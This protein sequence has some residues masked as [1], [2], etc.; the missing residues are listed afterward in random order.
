AMDDLYLDNI[1]ELVT[2]H[3]KIIS[4][5]SGFVCEKIYTHTHLSLSLM[6]YDYVERK[7]KESSAAQLHVTYLVSGKLVQDGSLPCHK[8]AVVRE[9]QLEA[10]KS[11]LAVTASVHVYSIQKALL[12]DSGPLFNTDYDAIKTNLQNCSKY[13]AIHCSEAVPRS[14]DEIDRLQKK[15]QEASQA[16][17]ETPVATKP[18]LNGHAPA[19]AKQAPQQPKGIMGMFAAKASSKPKAGNKEL[20]KEAKEETAAAPESSMKPA[21]RGNSTSNFF[22]KA[23]ASKLKASPQPAETSI[24][25]E[26]E[27]VKPSVPKEKESPAEKEKAAPTQREMPRAPESSEPAR[28]KPKDNKSKT[29]RA[30]GSDEEEGETES[31]RIKRRRIKQPQPDSSDEEEDSKEMGKGGREGGVVV[32]IFMM[33]QS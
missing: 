18:S 28:R 12:K 32:V 22:G 8:V 11:K 33:K 1:D 4:F 13:S 6:L 30:A 29:K 2:D 5:K 21:A 7:R 24:K 25:E 3:N 20:K 10:L 17:T 23:A 31:Q 14:L 27:E 19:P 16:S 15:A 26:E 9:E